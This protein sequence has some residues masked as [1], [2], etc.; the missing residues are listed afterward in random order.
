MPFYVT[1]S[2]GPTAALSEPVLATSD[3]V[4]VRATAKAIRDR[5]G[6]EP[7]RAAREATRTRPPDLDEGD[8]L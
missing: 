1:V 6:G 4:V 5:L 8:R 3:P 7:Q 2:E